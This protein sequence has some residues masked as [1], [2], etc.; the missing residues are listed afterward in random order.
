MERRPDGC[1][2]AQPGGLG[3]ER[4][5]PEEFHVVLQDDVFLGR[6]IAEERARRH[7]GGLGDLLHR[8]GVV[9]LLTEKPERVLP[10]GSTRPGLLALPQPRPARV[11]QRAHGAIL[12]LRGPGR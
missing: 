6:E 9:P 4:V 12:P 3:T 10:D 1:Y 11:R 2:R 5:D 8:G 7:L